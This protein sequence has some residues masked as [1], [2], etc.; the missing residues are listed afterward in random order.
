MCHKTGCFLGGSPFSN[1]NDPPVK[2]YLTTPLDWKGGRTHRKT[3][4]QKLL[5][6]TS[7]LEGR[8]NSQEHRTLHGCCKK[9]SH[10]APQA[11]NTFNNSITHLRDRASTLLLCDSIRLC[12]GFSVRGLIL[13]SFVLFLYSDELGQ[14]TA[15]TWLSLGNFTR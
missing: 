2:I 12:G 6:D 4:L 7:G 8:T 10:F 15:L 11:N 5:N 14:L 3:N 13:D 9:A 1:N